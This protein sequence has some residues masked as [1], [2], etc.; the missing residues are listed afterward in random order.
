MAE[1]DTRPEVQILPV[2]EEVPHIRRRRRVTGRVRVAVKTEEESVTL[3]ATLRHRHVEV[4]RVPIGRE[5]EEVPP[6]RQEGDT[7]IVPVLEERLVLIRRLVLTEEIHLRVATQEQA[8]QL[9]ATRLRQAVQIDR[10]PV[11]PQARPE[12]TTP[13]SGD[14]P[15]MACTI[16]G[17]FDSR[18]EA[19]R[20]RDALT[21]LGID[22]GRVRLHTVESGTAATTG[23]STGREDRGFL[24]SLAD[25]FVPDEDRATYG[26]GLR[27]GHVLVSAEVE[28]AHVDRAMDIMEEHGAMDLDSREAEWRSQG[29]STAGTGGAAGTGATAAGMTG[30]SGASTAG[31]T[32]ATSVTSLHDTQSG[33]AASTGMAGASTPEASMAGVGSTG[34]GQTGRTG[35]GRTGET[36]H[37]ESIPVVEE[38][39]RVGKREVRSGRVRVRSYVVETPV[40]EQVR[41]R[42]EHVQVER[43][44]VDR[45]AT[46]ADRALLKD[47]VIE[48][49]ETSEEAV[50]D[51]QLRV[52]EEITLRKDATEHTETVQDKIRR[53][54]VEVEDDRIANDPT[55]QGGRGAA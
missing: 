34:A 38:Q 15:D 17:M 51:K 12:P 7:V 2:L 31:T 40:Q 1:R 27:R 46:E 42:E 41:L 39:L 36:G 48:A 10:L 50:V 14:F 22:A 8:T 23:A 43:R 6:V 30:V 3:E 33:R 19:E 4:R 26:E 44:P 54:E 55:K 24:S 16:T 11:G 28:D 20:A 35:T 25:L 5:V 45:P 21:A 18:V 52:K 32:G 47:R 49:E 13:T 37:E 53:T 29:W 9:P